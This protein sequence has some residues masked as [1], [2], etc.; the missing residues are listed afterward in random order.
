MTHVDNHI[1]QVDSWPITASCCEIEVESEI[2]LRYHLMDVHGLSR[3]EMKMVGRKRTA[4]EENNIVDPPPLPI[5][6]TALAMPDHERGG[7]LQK[8]V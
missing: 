5:E 8:P 7:K 2:D 3:A 1:S 4:E 6:R